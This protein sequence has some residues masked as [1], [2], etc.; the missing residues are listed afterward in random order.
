M[1]QR[2]NGKLR[3]GIVGAG[4]IVRTRHLP[5][6]KKNPDADIV[7]VSNS[8]YESS[9]QFCKEHCPGATPMANWAD[10]L[11]GPDL[12]IICIG[13]SRSMH[14]AGTLSARRAGQHVFCQGRVAMDLADGVE[15]LP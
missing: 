10:L 1:A 15:A 5:A 3:I 7:A 11:A 8:T 2:N 12:E 6:L 9:E 13:P 14:S 4:N